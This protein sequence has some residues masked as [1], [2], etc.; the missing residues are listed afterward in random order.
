MVKDAIRQGVEMFL[1]IIM[2]FRTKWLKLS[3]YN[4]LP[5]TMT[6]MSKIL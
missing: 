5:L 1:W 3:T 2:D 6:I 4:F